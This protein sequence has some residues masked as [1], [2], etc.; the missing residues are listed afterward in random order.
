[1]QAGDCIDS[2]VAIDSERAEA[3]ELENLVIGRLGSPAYDKR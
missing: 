1:M 2:P 3:V